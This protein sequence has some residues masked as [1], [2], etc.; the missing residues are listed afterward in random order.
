MGAKGES[1]TPTRAGT[2]TIPML[3]N[4]DTYYLACVKMGGSF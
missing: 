3:D 1:R 2:I 4:T